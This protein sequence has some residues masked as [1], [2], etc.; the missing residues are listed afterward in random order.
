M[1][2]PRQGPTPTRRLQPPGFLAL[3][4][5]KATPVSTLV[6]H[7]VYGASL[8]ILYPLHGG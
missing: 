1:A 8:G 3:Y 5:G 6:A 4:Y 7:I 2:S